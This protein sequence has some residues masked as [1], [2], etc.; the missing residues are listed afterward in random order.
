MSGRAVMSK[1]IAVG[2]M[3]SVVVTF[4]YIQTGSAALIKVAAPSTIIGG[5]LFGFGIVLAGGCET[6]MMYRAMEGQ[7]LF[8]VVGIGNVVGATVLAYGWDH[9]GIFDALVKSWTPVNLINVWGSTGALLG[10]IAMLLVWF[11]LSNWWEN[12]YRYGSGFKKPD[13]NQLSHRTKEA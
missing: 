6:G 10:T 4:F 11:L 13:T 8:W 7:L 1:A 2:M 9:F 12:R 5:L 3:I